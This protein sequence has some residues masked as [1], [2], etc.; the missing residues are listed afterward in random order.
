MAVNTYNLGRVGLHIRG[1]Y[2]AADTYET[3]DVVT[4]NGSSYA[5]KAGCQNVTPTDTQYWV[6]LAQGNPVNSVT[7]MEQLPETG[8]LGQIVFVPAE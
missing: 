3:L 2:N 7:Y 1:E 8:T 5:A 4:Y 6:L